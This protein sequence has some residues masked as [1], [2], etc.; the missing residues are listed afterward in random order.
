MSENASTHPH[1]I[2][3]NDASLYI[4]GYEFGPGVSKIII[5]LS[6]TVDN[7]KKEGASICTNGKER[8][9]QNIYLSNSKGDH[10]S[11][12]SNYV[13]IELDITMEPNCSP[14]SFNWKTFQNE[15]AQKYEVKATFHFTVDGK[16]YDTSFEGDCIKNRICPATEQ[17]TYHSTFSGKYKNPMTQND[18]L[19]TL[20]I[21]A[22]EPKHL[23]EDNAKNPLIIWLHGQG[24]GGKD[25]EIALL[26]NQVT[27]LITPK[28]QSY[29]TTKNGSTGAYVL[30]VQTPTYWMDGGDG[31]NSNGDVESR[32]TQALMDAIKDY[33]SKNPD[34]DTNRIYLGGCS[35][36]GFMTMNLL[37]NYPDYW[38]ASY[39]TCEAYPFMKC[40]RDSEGKYI[41]K[42]GSQF[43]SEVL[44]SEERWFTDEKL[45]AIKNI[46]M[47][48]VHCAEDPLVSAV[49]F[50]FPAYKELLKLGAKNCW[51]SYFQTVEGKDIPGMKYFGHWVW[52][53]LFN[54]QI[55]RVQDREKILNSSD[56][57]T[58][59]YVANNEGGGTQKAA[60]DKGTYESIFAW[61]NAQVKK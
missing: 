20:Q 41:V 11:T 36:G 14:F 49:R 10:A 43:A 51:Y 48:L 53:R 23:K 26:G 34:I 52:I 13:T 38:A 2:N 32:Y 57:E 39:M 58:F 16:D 18:D 4:S 5:S 12:S 25:I 6:R 9:I 19:V 47:W 3:V 46:P 27:A 28:I 29:F 40:Q 31:V 33:V 44:P 60:D 61:L 22:Y 1:S 55:T 59:G 56:Q 21:G 8:T 54:D 42:E 17:F 50:S 37:I 30:A 45:N 24:E 7:V 15:W 35:N